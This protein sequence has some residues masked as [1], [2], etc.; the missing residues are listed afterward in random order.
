MPGCG[1]VTGVM[2]PW[3]PG[4][5]DGT[6]PCW[7]GSRGRGSLALVEEGDSYLRE[8]T[9]NKVRSDNHQYDHL[10]QRESSV[11]T[12]FRAEGR[13]LG[14]VLPITDQLAIRKHCI[15][16]PW[17]AHCNVPAISPV[18]QECPQME[19][20]LCVLRFDKSTKGDND[21][22]IS[23]RSI[24]SQERGDIFID[25]S[26]QPVH[27]RRPVGPPR[28]R[29]LQGSI[30][31]PVGGLKGWRVELGWAGAFPFTVGSSLRVAWPGEL[32]LKVEAS[33]CRSSRSIPDDK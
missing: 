5:E 26:G 23:K 21:D 32:G 20:V 12:P 10:R 28:G 29:Q 14:L 30:V 9:C 24:Y 27:S 18:T 15:R 11:L 22:V 6:G 7:R 17:L 13:T 16:A 33:P 8:Q 25:P 4:S 1:P 3:L 19:L 2:A 31:G